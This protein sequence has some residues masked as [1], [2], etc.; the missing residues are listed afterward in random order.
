MSYI[1]GRTVHDADSHVMELPGTIMEFLESPA[2][3]QAP[4]M[5]YSSLMQSLARDD[6]RRALDWAASLRTDQVQLIRFDSAC[7][8]AKSRC[9]TLWHLSSVGTDTYGTTSMILSLTSV[10]GSPSRVSVISFSVRY[11]SSRPSRPTPPS[12]RQPWR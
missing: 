8:H 5:V 4:S 12:S 3:E 9:P 10:G 6:P 2:G 11:N 1:E 7:R